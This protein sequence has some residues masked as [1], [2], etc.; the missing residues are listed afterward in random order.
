MLERQQARMGSVD[1]WS[2]RPILLRVDAAA[3]QVRRK[4]DQMIA[5]EAAPST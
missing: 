3:I 5:S 2:L 4:L 1:F